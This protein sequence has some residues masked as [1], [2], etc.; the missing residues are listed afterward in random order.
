MPRTDFPT[1][2]FSDFALRWRF[3]LHEHHVLSETDLRQIQP[4]E[5]ASARQLLMLVSGRCPIAPVRGE[6]PVISSL[7]VGGPEDVLRVQTWLRQLG[8]SPDER[9]LLSW[10]ASDAATTTWR[11]FVTYW[12]VFWYPSSDDLTVVDTD[13]TWSLFLSHEEEA[14]FAPHP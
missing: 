5:R 3:T 7:S 1:I 12:N 6:R 13:F 11:I 14:S 10:N 8:I 4:L 2:P 9:V